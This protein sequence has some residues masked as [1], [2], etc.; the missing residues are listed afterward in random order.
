MHD[1][2]LLAGIVALLAIV[3]SVFGMGIL[4]FGTPTLLLMGYDFT[5]VLGLLLPASVSI[6][7][8]Q[9]WS[10]RQRGVPA[11]E[12]VTMVICAIAV[13]VSLAMLVRLNLKA[14]VDM[15]IGLAM[16]SAAAVRYSSRLQAGLRRFIHA[17]SRLYVGSMGVVHGLTNMGGALLA[18]YAASRY[19]D[20]HAVRAAISRYYLLFGTIQLGTVALLRPAA[21]DVRGAVMAPIAVA[22]YFAV[23]N[24]LFARAGAPLYERAMTAFIGVYG[25]VVLAKT[26]VFA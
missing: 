25:A 12:R 8:V 11:A 2:H 23:G 19:D 24:V 9:A 14:R 15:L 3:Q 10:A 21:L 20:K 17:R 16:L 22:I 26:L 1:P 13:L 7:A 6:S 5:S 18:V 4:V